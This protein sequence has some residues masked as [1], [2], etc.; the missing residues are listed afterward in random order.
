MAY[1]IIDY[2]KQ[3]GRFVHLSAMI[4]GAKRKILKE[5]GIML[6]ELRKRRKMSQRELSAASG[7]EHPQISLMEKGARNPTYTTILSL[8]EALGV[9]PGDLFPR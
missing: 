3:S 5:F 7:V 2:T 1:V 8:A 9:H 6:K 4:E